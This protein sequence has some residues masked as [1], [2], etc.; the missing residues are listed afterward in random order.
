MSNFI[1]LA[2]EKLDVED[3]IVEKMNII[4]AIYQKGLIEG[5]NKGVSICNSRIQGL[6]PPSHY[7]SEVYRF[8]KKT[9]Q[10]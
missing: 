2:L 4:T 8:D 1:E 5:Y 9:N 10:P 3:C 7:F 6:K